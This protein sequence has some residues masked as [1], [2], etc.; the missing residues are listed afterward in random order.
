MH[1]APARVEKSQSILSFDK[2]Y[3][4]SSFMAGVPKKSV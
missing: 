4:E 1:L 3:L 2:D